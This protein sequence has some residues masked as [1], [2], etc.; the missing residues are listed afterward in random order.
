MLTREGH[1]R[2]NFI[3]GVV[4][5]ALFSFGSAFVDANTVLPVFIRHFSGSDSMVGLASSVR[6]AGWYLAQLPMAGIL[7]RRAYK[8]P[9]YIWANVVRMA[10]NWAFI[11]FLALYAVQRPQ[12]V[13]AGFIA[14]FMV[15]SIFGGMAGA[16]FTDIVAKTIPRRHRGPFYALRFFFGAGI[17]SIVAGFIVRYIL[18]EDS[19]FGFPHNYVLIFALS[20]LLMTVGIVCYG[21]VKE[22]P[23]RVSEKRRTFP[24]VASEVPGILRSDGNYRRLLVCQ[25]LAAGLGFSLPFYVVLAHERFGVTA[26]TVG[27]FLAFQTIGQTGANLV[28]GRLSSRR[29]NRMVIRL[30]LGIQVLIPLYALFLSNVV[31]EVILAEGGWLVTASFAPIFLLIGGTLSGSFVGFNSFLLDVAPED[32]RPTYVGITNTSMGCASFFPALGGV[33]ADTV[34]LDGVF[35]LSGISICAAIAVSRRLKEPE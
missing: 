25:V 34:A 33:L 10:L 8:R 7:E 18:R 17:L 21:F 4:N 1:L 28:W 5:G 20:S 29:G 14:I 16:P 32:R 6:S 23:G 12:W 3:L 2:H 24:D 19:L 26:S 9:F 30:V 31:P 13:L 15:S 11:P 27:L 35:L 22:P